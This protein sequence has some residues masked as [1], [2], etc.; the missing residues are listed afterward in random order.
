MN[1]L[2][3]NS[4]RYDL[5]HGFRR[6]RSCES[7][8]LQLVRDLAQGINNSG[9]TDMA[10]LDFSKAFDVVPHRRLLNKLEWY[11]VSSKVNNW[12]RSFLS[13]QRVVVDG[14]R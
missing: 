14:I 7:Q 10:I 5:Q 4:I 11:G 6:N 13:N 2:E 12:I 1:H 9:Q 3:E 8:L